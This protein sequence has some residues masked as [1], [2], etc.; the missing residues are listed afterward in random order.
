MIGKLDGGSSPPMTT[1]VMG[2]LRVCAASVKTT[3]Q[4]VCD[5][6][7]GGMLLCFAVAEA[8]FRRCLALPLRPR[9]RTLWQY[10]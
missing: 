5:G 7:S 9:T 2:M 4:L 3:P 10:P 1:I 8:L 6:L